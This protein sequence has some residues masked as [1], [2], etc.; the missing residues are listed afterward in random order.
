M[1]KC[2]YNNENLK[3]TLVN[4]ASSGQRSNT[5]VLRASSQQTLH[6]WSHTISLKEWQKHFWWRDHCLGETWGWS[7]GCV[8][9]GQVR[10]LGQEKAE[11]HLPGKGSC[12]I[13]V[14]NWIC[15]TIMNHC[16]C[17][18]KRRDRIQN[19]SKE[20][21]PEGS[22]RKTAQGK[23]FTCSVQGLD[24]HL[25]LWWLGV[26]LKSRDQAPWS[27]GSACRAHLHAYGI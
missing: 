20:D 14:P 13:Q 16:G 25:N 21:S 24:E 12:L 15:N 17:L 7:S 11:S 10:V 18:N 3:A 22:V 27:L 5:R 2:P 8:L 4:G 6:N 19:T 9:S 1:R 23:E 26:L